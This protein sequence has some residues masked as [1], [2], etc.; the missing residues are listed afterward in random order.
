VYPAQVQ[1]VEGGDAVYTNGAMYVSRATP[2]AH[3]ALPSPPGRL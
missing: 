2:S 3:R 1:Y